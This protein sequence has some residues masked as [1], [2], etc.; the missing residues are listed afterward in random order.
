M[1]FLDSGGFLNIFNSLQN[2]GLIL[3][4]KDHLVFFG[5]DQ[6]KVPTNSPSY[7]LLHQVHEDTIVESKNKT[8]LADGHWT[9]KK[10]L[11]LV[12]KTAD[13]L[14]V[15]L[16]NQNKVVALHIGWRG[17]TNKIIEKSAKFFN[18]P[19]EVQCYIGPHIGYSSFQVS[20]SIA[21]DILLARSLSWNQVFKNDWAKRSYD[22]PNHLYLNLQAILIHE[23]TKLGYKKF[24]LTTTNTTTSHE[25]FS[26]RRNRHRIG[27]NYSLIIKL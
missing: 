23:L 7:R 16:A 24:T 27:T 26:H 18:N 22:R 13:C 10:N 11:A 1:N 3:K 20:D 5:N 15:F 9:T 21:T 4:A 14:P 6:F 19:E 12:I 17:F 8:Q 2:K 25:H